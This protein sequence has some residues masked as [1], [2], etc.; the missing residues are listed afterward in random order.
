MLLV[1][2]SATISYSAYFCAYGPPARMIRSYIFR[3]FFSFQGHFHFIFFDTLIW[4]HI[5]Y[6]IL[7]A[8][9]KRLALSGHRFSPPGIAY[10]RAYFDIFRCSASSDF[11]FQ[12][13]YKIFDA[14]PCARRFRPHSF[15]TLLHWYRARRQSKIRHLDEI[16]DRYDFRVDAWPFPRP[17][18]FSLFIVARFILSFPRP[19]SLRFSLTE[20]AKDIF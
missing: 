9:L 12:P 14:R 18:L 15:L 1:A 8:R 5:R 4:G 20:R 17:A 13:H 16:F 11:K 6:H 10:F 7:A 3:Y 2:I 19:V